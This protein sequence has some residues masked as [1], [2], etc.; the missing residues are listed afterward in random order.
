MYFRPICIVC[1]FGAI[2][3]A[4]CAFLPCSTAETLTLVVNNYFEQINDNDD[5][6]TN[7]LFEP[8]FGELGVTY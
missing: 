6:T 2:V 7:S 1:I 5:V 4:L 3:R 8:P